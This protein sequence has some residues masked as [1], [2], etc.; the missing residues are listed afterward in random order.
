MAFICYIYVCIYIH[1]HFIYLTLMD[2]TCC[3]IFGTDGCSKQAN[4]AQAS[5][6]LCSMYAPRGANKQRPLTRLVYINSEILSLL[7]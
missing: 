4:P 5:T 1:I 2:P 7:W 3:N 6:S